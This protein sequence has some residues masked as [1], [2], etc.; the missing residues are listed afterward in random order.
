M[1]KIEF[2]LLYKKFRMIYLVTGFDHF[3]PKFYHF[4]VLD[5]IKIENEVNYLLPG[6]DLLERKS[7]VLC[8]YRSPGKKVRI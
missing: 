3:S 4:T 2:K 6:F 7:R 5:K 1:I 8:L